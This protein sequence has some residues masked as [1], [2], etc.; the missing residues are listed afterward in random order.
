MHTLPIVFTYLDTL[1]CYYTYYIMLCCILSTHSI[2]QMSVEILIFNMYVKG[3]FSGMFKSGYGF[4]YL[5]MCALR[6]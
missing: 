3:C 1:S 6:S 4:A 2:L 5:V